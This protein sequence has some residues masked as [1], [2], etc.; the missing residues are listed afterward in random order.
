MFPLS[1]F[2]AGCG[3]NFSIGEVSSDEILRRAELRI[4]MK[5]P[6]GD[7][8]N[9]VYLRLYHGRRKGGYKKV[10]PIREGWVVFDVINE[11]NQWRAANH[12]HKKIHFY[13][14]TYTSEEDLIKGQNGKNCHDS[15]IKFHQPTGNN[16]SD[17]EV[18]NKPLLMIYSH[19]LNTFMFDVDAIKNATEE[20]KREHRSTSTENSTEVLNQGCTKHNLQI[21]LETFNKIWRLGHSSQLALYPPNIDINVCGGQCQHNVPLSS[22]QHSIVLFYLAIRHSPPYDNVEW[23]QCCAPVKY[24]NLE[25]LFT[26]P[27]DEMRIV[28]LKNLSVER[29]SCLNIIQP[30][31]QTR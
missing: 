29:C 11:I 10:S 25:V 27:N 31:S 26:L 24:K 16:D 2:N 30:T 9:A 23:S 21:S 18:D 6:T 4:H 8:V 19:D 17:T 20:K 15:P 3:F 13:I 7:Q 12:P 1:L 22:A 14:V 28:L 5:Q